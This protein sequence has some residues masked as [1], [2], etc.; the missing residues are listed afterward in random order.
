METF[1]FFFVL[2]LLFTK[3]QYSDLCAKY[4]A[5][6]AMHIEW[7]KIYIVV[8]CMDDGVKETL[9]CAVFNDDWTIICSFQSDG[10]PVASVHKVRMDRICQTFISHL[11]S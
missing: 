2:F 1:L 10:L 6:A 11:E 7:E 4:G 3:Q 8:E 5:L 9:N